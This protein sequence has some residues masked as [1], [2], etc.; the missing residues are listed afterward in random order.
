MYEDA[1]ARLADILEADPVLRREYDRYHK[2]QDDPRVTRIGKLLRRYSLDEL[3]QILNV[4]RGDM[5]LV[6]PRAYMP[7]ELQKMS[8][9]ARTV[10][11]SPPG[12]TGLWQV[13]GRNELSF[14]DRVSLDVHYIQNWSP[15][16]DLY[17]LVRTG[18]VV[19]SGEGAA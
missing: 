6:G 8:G 18:P 15:W 7:S 1:D 10:L 12:M 19:L 2:L 13:S 3:P 4:L 11:Q 16:L 14:S 9:L 17:L 5:S